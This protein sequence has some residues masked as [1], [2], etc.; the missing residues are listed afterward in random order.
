MVAIVSGWCFLKFESKHFG[1]SK[2]AAAKSKGASAV[3]L[4]RPL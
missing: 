3:K 4:L 2:F 1:G